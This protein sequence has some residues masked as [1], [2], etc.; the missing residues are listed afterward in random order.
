MAFRRASL[1]AKIFPNVSLVMVL[2]RLV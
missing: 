1:L 2:F